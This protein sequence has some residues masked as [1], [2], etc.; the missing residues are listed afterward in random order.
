MEI[1]LGRGFSRRADEVC[2][3]AAAVAGL[4]SPDQSAD[5][6]PLL[7][8]YRDALAAAIASG[9]EA[10]RRQDPD[11][12]GPTYINGILIANKTYALPS[13]WGD[14]LTAETAPTSTP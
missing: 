14:G 9:E 13:W 8:G 5:L 11:S 7:Q 2:L 12:A 3:S 6:V 10:A 1:R 4:K